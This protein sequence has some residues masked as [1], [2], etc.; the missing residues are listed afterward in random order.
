M[1]VKTGIVRHRKHKKTLSLAKGYWMSR[2]KLYKKA[3]EAVLHAGVYAYHGRKKR[4][5][6]FRRL[7]I[8]RINAGLTDTGLSYSRFIR[9]LSLNKIELDRKILAELALNHQ[10][11]WQKVVDATAKSKKPSA[12]AN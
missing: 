6:D 12:G 7:W 11:V 1:R 8:Q 4:K 3:K 2:S 9:A 5:R 10:S